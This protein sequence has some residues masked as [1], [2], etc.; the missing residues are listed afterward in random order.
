[1]TNRISVFIYSLYPVYVRILF[2][3]LYINMGFPPHI[4]IDSLGCI[5]RVILFQTRMFFANSSHRLSV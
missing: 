5:L 3:V 4:N 1:M 2:I